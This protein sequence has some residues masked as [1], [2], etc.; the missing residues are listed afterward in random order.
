MVFS[1]LY[2]LPWQRSILQVLWLTNEIAYTEYSPLIKGNYHLIWC[3]LILLNIVFHPLF[4]YINLVFDIFY[5]CNGQKHAYICFYGNVVVCLNTNSLILCLHVCI[6]CDPISVRKLPKR[7]TSSC[8]YC[9]IKVYT[10]CL[11][12]KLYFSYDIKRLDDFSIL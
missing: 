3:V 6:P 7:R 11:F 10:A 4:S 2:L 12:N 1:H 5:G 9:L 8:R